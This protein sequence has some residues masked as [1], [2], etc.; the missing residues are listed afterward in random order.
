MFI[1][2]SLGGRY[3]Y[4][5][6]DSCCVKADRANSPTWASGRHWQLTLGFAL[7][8]SSRTSHHFLTSD[9][10]QTGRQTDDGL[11]VPVLQPC[12]DWPLNLRT[13]LA[14]SRRHA[15]RKPCRLHTGVN[16]PSAEVVA[17]DSTT[18]TVHALGRPWM[19]RS[20]ELTQWAGG[21]AT[22]PRAGP[23]LGRLCALHHQ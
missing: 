7:A 6:H 15:R 8:T 17:L 20:F 14:K 11:D 5:T 22:T 1:W 23:L 13:R 10:P 9:G 21:F 2:D 19:A 16:A 18:T 12:S 4:R 3:W